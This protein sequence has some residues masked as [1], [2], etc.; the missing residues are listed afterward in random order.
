MNVDHELM[1]SNVQVHKFTLF[2][3]NLR[4]RSRSSSSRMIVIHSSSSSSSQ[5]KKDVDRE[6]NNVQVHN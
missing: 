2:F 3:T 1:K 4:S 6:H 5:K